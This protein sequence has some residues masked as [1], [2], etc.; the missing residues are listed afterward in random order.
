M[1]NIINDNAYS[2]FSLT[3]WKFENTPMTMILIWDAFFL[4]KSKLS[5]NSYIHIIQTHIF[6]QIASRCSELIKHTIYA[7]GRPTN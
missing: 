3:V 5:I 6:K 7:L 1:K 2:K 4:W